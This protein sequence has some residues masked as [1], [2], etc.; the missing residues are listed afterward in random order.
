MPM[1]GGVWISEAELFAEEQQG[2]G[3]FDK[4]PADVG[5]GILGIGQGDPSIIS[6]IPDF[7]MDENQQINGTNP[8]TGLPFLTDPQVPETAVTI[9]PTTGRDVSGAGTPAPTRKIVGEPTGLESLSDTLQ[10]GLTP[11]Q[12]IYDP[13]IEVTK[14]GLEEQEGI[15]QQAGEELF[16]AQTIYDQGRTLAQFQ[17][18]MADLNYTTIPGTDIP[19][20]QNEQDLKAYYGG[21]AF[22]DIEK[23]LKS[24]MANLPTPELEAERISAR[25]RAI[26][27]KPSDMPDSE[28]TYPNPVTGAV[29]NVY[30]TPA[31]DYRQQAGEVT[32]ATG[33]Q[34][35]ADFSDEEFSTAWERVARGETSIKDLGPMLRF[36]PVVTDLTVIDPRT[37]EPL[38]S[39]VLT[40]RSKM[41]LEQAEIQADVKHK[42]RFDEFNK[43]LEQAELT[44][45]FSLVGQ[46][47]I[48]TIE[49]R[50]LTL[51][52][53][54]AK[55]ELT[56]FY[57][58]DETLKKQ[59]FDRRQSQIDFD[60][61]L[62][63]AATTGEFYTVDKDGN[64]TETAIGTLAKKKYQ[65][66]RNQ[67]VIQRAFEV[68]D[69]T[70][71]MF[72]TEYDE[73]DNLITI[74]TK[75]LTQAGDRFKQE[76][77]WDTARYNEWKANVDAKMT[78]EDL[79]MLEIMGTSNEGG[80][81]FMTDKTGTRVLDEKGDP[82]S[83]SMAARQLAYD[84]EQQDLQKTDIDARYE[85]LKR[86]NLEQEANALAE[87]YGVSFIVDP[88]TGEKT[89]E[90]VRV[91]ID[92]EKGLYEMVD[93]KT[94][95]TQKW[96]SQK[97]V[98]LEAELRRKLEWEGEMN[99]ASRQL[100]ETGR[101]H[102]TEMK[103]RN[104]AAMRQE[105]FTERQ[106]DEVIRSAQI[107]EDIERSQ[108]TGVYYSPEDYEIDPDT[109]VRYL[110]SGAVGIDTY[111]AREQQD[112]KDRE[113]RRILMEATGYLVGEDGN[114][115]LDDQG[116]PMLLESAR[117]RQF[118]E[119]LAITAA[120][121]ETRRINEI[122]TASQAGTK[123]GIDRLDEEI[124]V[125]GIEET[126]ERDEFNE[127]KRR[128]LAGEDQ[129]AKE[130][131]ERMR[132]AK[133]GETLE[134]FRAQT[135]RGLGARQ[136]TEDERAAREGESLSREELKLGQRQLTEA[137]RAAQERE[138]LSRDE[139]DFAIR[140]AGTGN[141]LQRDRLE[142]EITE[143]RVEQ[144]MD[145]KEFAELVRRAYAGEEQ[146]A[147]EL[148]ER[149]RAARAGESLAERQL[150]QEERASQQELTFRREQ[151]QSENERAQLQAQ[152]SMLQSILQNPY[153]FGALQAM[154]QGQLPGVGGMAVPAPTAQ[155]QGVAGPIA[156][157]FGGGVP[158]TGGLQ[159]MDPAA[160]GILTDILGFRGISPE[161]LGRTSA[162]Y[163]PGGRQFAPGQIF[164]GGLAR[165][166]RA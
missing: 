165:G 38:V 85:E 70:G 31:I 111:Q 139:L 157:L 29:E 51:Q 156:A 93:V 153:A 108:I 54:M 102:D 144:S 16:R 1:R 135:E 90:K 39:M 40:E 48:E 33:Q 35:A 73:A 45:D 8:L 61:R 7:M 20:F 115:V 62:A 132:A 81:F 119:G 136:L 71:F 10:T 112:A 89:R 101:I 21:A 128:A 24:I 123:L 134:A 53:D 121:D 60:R 91:A 5:G 74:P 152:V 159:Q 50:Q 28:L 13:S 26:M 68:A 69:R 118:Q 113:D 120:D 32:R 17:K 150:T 98:A 151:M 94:L 4:P 56:G 84:I 22:S 127:L 149:I 52:E 163:T 145:E 58:K 96:E 105:G 104:R 116:K 106:I 133:R 87:L 138:G 66:E 146:S 3:T 107:N 23:G 130:L 95:A 47:K 76:L 78:P 140:Q 141:E 125:S 86:A 12:S 100:T 55:A 160:L 158:T 166:R 117:A 131:S 36:D 97:A 49:Q 57:G 79:K 161:Q 2:G 122:I 6:N 88:V 75:D 27:E 126:L 59:E 43:A 80:A 41:L 82:L 162:G 44:G 30:E 148:S 37:G 142:Q 63:E 42:T 124:R 103:E 155:Q 65:A 14:T 164:T 25:N 147:K 92:A 137:E 64:R 77:E 9:D 114:Y 11:G 15:E 72:T 34:G 110:K 154:Q 83:I 99:F 129:A 18:R 109:G 143:S 67:M 19:V 46:D